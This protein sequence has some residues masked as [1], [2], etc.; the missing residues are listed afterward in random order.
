MH[1]LVRRVIVCGSCGGHITLY[2]IKCPYCGNTLEPLGDTRHVLPHSIESPYAVSDAQA[3]K[4]HLEEL[5]RF[6]SFR[7]VDVDDLYKAIDPLRHHQYPYRE[8]IIDTLSLI[9]HFRSICTDYHGKDTRDIYLEI[10]KRVEAIYHSLT[11]TS[12]Y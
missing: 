6:Q 5:E 9:V 1:T 12:V 8:Y 10:Y 4:P 2:D 3:I 7:P 11:G